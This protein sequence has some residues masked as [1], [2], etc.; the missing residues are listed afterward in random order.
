MK[1]LR[2]ESRQN[3]H[4]PPRYLNP[5]TI[6]FFNMTTDLH[7]SAPEPA[8]FNKRIAQEA[9]AEWKRFTLSIHPALVAKDP[10]NELVHQSRSSLNDGFFHYQRHIFETGGTSAKR[11]HSLGRQRDAHR[12]RQE[13]GGKAG[14]DKEDESEEKEKEEE[15]YEEWEPSNKDWETMEHV[16]QIWQ[17]RC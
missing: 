17:H 8:N 4:P 14:E 10:D 2:R 5:T 7:P 11:F 13:E 6:E 3:F 9:M 16:G 12:R 15:D 1:Y